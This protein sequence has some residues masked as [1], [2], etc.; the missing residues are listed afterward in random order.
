MQWK[1]SKLKNLALTQGWAVI[2]DGVHFRN[3]FSD[4]GPPWKAWAKGVGPGHFHV[5]P[6]TDPD[7]P[8]DGG[9]KCMKSLPP[10]PPERNSSCSEMLVV[11]SRHP[12]PWRREE[13]SHTP[14]APRSIRAWWWGEQAESP[15][16]LQGACN[17]L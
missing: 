13:T 4:P 3:F 7:W 6:P 11:P 10:P 9:G 8:G 2:L 14:S 17:A 15:P 16:I 1:W 5:S 12:C